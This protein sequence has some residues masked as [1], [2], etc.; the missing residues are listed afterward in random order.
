MTDEQISR[1]TITEI[2]EL[3]TRL[4]QEIEIRFMQFY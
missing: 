4:L 2:R 3:I 1:L